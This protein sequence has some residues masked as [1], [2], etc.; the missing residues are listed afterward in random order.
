M[1]EDRARDPR[2]QPRVEEVRAQYGNDSFKNANAAEF[3]NAKKLNII[4]RSK[5]ETVG[6]NLSKAMDL[7]NGPAGQARDKS[8]RRIYN[9]HGG[10]GAKQRGEAWTRFD[11]HGDKY[12]SK[13][14]D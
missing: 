2:R 6:G 3:I 10:Y 4:D 7:A 11:K 9:I 13:D 5:G 14:Q 1:A 8:L 12:E